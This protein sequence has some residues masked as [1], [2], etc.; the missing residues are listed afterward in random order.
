MKTINEVLHPVDFN[1]V[2][3][4]DYLYGREVKY[5]SKQEGNDLIDD[6]DIIFVTDIYLNKMVVF[7]EITVST[8]EWSQG[9]TQ[10]KKPLHTF[11]VSR[12][13]KDKAFKD[14]VKADFASHNFKITE[15]EY[16]AKRNK[17]IEDINYIFKGSKMND[18]EKHIIA[19]SMA[20]EFGV[21]PAY[22][23]KQIK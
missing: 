5:C 11:P 15:A 16:D 18:A 6:T 7:T 13:R 10:G 12:V 3:N 23:L 8:G 22:I 14:F 9:I 20:K 1:K 19:K 21:T 17:M 2:L 4:F